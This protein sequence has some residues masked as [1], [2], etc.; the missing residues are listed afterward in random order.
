MLVEPD[1]SAR[2]VITI[3]IDISPLS[4]KKME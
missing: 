4:S 3:T 1:R 2:H